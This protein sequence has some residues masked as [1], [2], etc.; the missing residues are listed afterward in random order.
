MTLN[1]GFDHI[2][3]ATSPSQVIASELGKQ[4]TSPK[5]VE[6]V[7][8]VQE[9][10]VYEDAEHEPELHLRTG[11]A[12]AAIWVYNLVIVFALNSLLQLYV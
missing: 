4:P 11:I 2:D 5:H 8:V 9:N 12:L 10:L 6:Q 7:N 1:I 3:R